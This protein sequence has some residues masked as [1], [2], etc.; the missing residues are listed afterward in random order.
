MSFFNDMISRLTDVYNKSPLSNIGKIIT[1]LTDELEQL[2]D[3]FDRIEEWEDVDNAKG[4][5]LDD[6]GEN[7][8][9]ARGSA[10]DEVY[11]IMLKSKVA[12]NLSD[13]AIDTIIRVLSIALNVDY[14]EIRIKEL[15][16]DADNP[17]PAA[18]GLIQ[19]PLRRLNEVGMSAKQFI[20]IVQKTV[21][22]GIRVANIEL[23]GTFS[24][25]SKNGVVEVDNDK[26][27]ADVG[28][29]FGGYFGATFTDSNDS[30]IPV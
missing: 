23:T 16:N 20:S 5:V 6:L 17:E 25:S 2:K 13:G 19:I 1:L 8:V 7:V 21:G 11:R 3:T 29:T 12:R 24:F 14:S 4:K 9:Q 22:S 10:T 30:S 18:I 26:G 28:Q 27:F 15:Y